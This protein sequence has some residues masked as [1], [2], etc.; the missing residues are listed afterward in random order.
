MATRLVTKLAAL[1]AAL[2]LG[3]PIS[4]ALADKRIALVI[5]NSGYQSVARLPNPANDA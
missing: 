3:L 2:W 4:A 1:G 5:G